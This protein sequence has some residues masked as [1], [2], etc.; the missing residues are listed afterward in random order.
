MGDRMGHTRF[1]QHTHQNLKYYVYIYRDPRNGEVFY[2]G[3]GKGDRAFIHLSDKSERRKVTRIRAI[4]AAGYEPEIQ[5]LTHGLSDPVTALKVEAAI[6][7]LFGLKVLTNNVRGFESHAFGAMTID[8]LVSR[9]NA[10]PAKIEESVCLIR[11]NQLFRYGMSEQELYD[12]TRGIWRTN[13]HKHKP[14]FAFAVYDK[15]VQEVYAIADWFPAGTTF[16]GRR[17]LNELMGKEDA[18]RWEFVGQIA[19]EPI[20]KRYRFKSV[21][22]Y[23]NSQNPIRYVKC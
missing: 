10:P 6:I 8:Q 9:Y 20:R 11:V 3:K 12:A 21:E 5:I 17:K 13:P 4:R 16:S 14:K 15:V 22:G 18:Q 7:D 2:V 19:R 23:L 1:P